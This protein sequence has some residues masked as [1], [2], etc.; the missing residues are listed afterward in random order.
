[1]STTLDAINVERMPAWIAEYTR[2]ANQ[3]AGNAIDA[4]EHGHVRM[5][6]RYEREA[7]FYRA[8]AEKTKANQIGFASR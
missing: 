7:T 3:A 2:W 8:L 5:A 6:A 4:R 1:M